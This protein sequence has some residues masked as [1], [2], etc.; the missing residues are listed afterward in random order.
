MLMALPSSPDRDGTET[1]GSLSLEHGTPGMVPL[2][3][4]WSR[5]SRITPVYGI[6]RE[7]LVEVGRLHPNIVINGEENRV[8]ALGPPISGKGMK[9]MLCH[10]ITDLLYAAD[11]NSVL[12]TSVV[13]DCTTGEVVQGGVNLGL[14][15][16]SNM[17]S[18]DEWTQERGLYSALDIPQSNKGEA[19]GVRSLNMTPAPPYSMESGFIHEVS[20]DNENACLWSASFTPPG[21]ITHIHADY[22]GAAQYMVHVC[23]KKVWLIWPPTETNLSI[24]APFLGAQRRQEL[25]MLAIEKMEKMEVFFIESEEGEGRKAFVIPPFYFHCCI[26][27]T[28]S[29]HIGVRIWGFEILDEA[30]E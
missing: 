19:L 17:F 10:V 13:V 9:I 2:L 6:G 1:T 11:K 20:D 25:T 3:D 16:A 24:M 8:K 18:P 22:I 27:I 4:A 26:S 29:C 5:N 30:Q 21:C 15:L 12:R 23:G 28:Q 14:F 7:I